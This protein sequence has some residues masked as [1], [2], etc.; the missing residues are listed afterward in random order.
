[1]KILIA[2]DNVDAAQTLGTL[3]ELIGHHVEVVYDGA[4]ALQAHASFAPEAV[5]CD[6][7]MPQMDGYEVA[8]RIRGGA[9]PRQPLMIAC[10][11]YGNPADMRSALAAGFDH[12]LTKPAE[13]TELLRLLAARIGSAGEAGAARAEPGCA[14]P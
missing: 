8:R 13:I 10:T 5:I 6:I 4:A 1:V 11:G 7:G 12:H 2:D 9:A 14:A 3:L